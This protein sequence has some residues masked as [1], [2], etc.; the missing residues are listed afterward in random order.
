MEHSQHFA[1]LLEGLESQ[2][3]SLGLSHYAVS[4]PTLE[5]VFLRC[6]AQSQDEQSRPEQSGSRPAIYAAV[7]AADAH[8]RI[9]LTPQGAAAAT[10]ALPRTSTAHGTSRPGSSSSGAADH[11]RDFEQHKSSP[12][13]KWLEGKEGMPQ[14]DVASGT[15]LPGSRDEDSGED[16]PPLTTI[17]RDDSAE[18]LSPAALEHVPAR[19]HLNGKAEDGVD[20]VGHESD[21]AEMH[22]QQGDQGNMEEVSLRED[23]TPVRVP[24][25]RKQRRYGVAFRE[26]LRKRFITAGEHH[27]RLILQSSQSLH[28]DAVSDKCIELAACMSNRSLS[29]GLIY[30]CDIK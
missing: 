22:T 25:Q 10:N 19:R 30:L 23:P 27:Y 26:M 8:C 17:S 16:L 3:S 9:Q 7:P 6:T 13:R 11:I 24:Q 4:M 28:R 21:S 12:R 20:E 5:E 18:V 2:C 29:Y 15:G 14:E 1:D